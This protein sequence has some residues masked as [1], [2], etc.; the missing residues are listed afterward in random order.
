MANRRVPDTNTPVSRYR[1]KKIGD[2]GNANAYNLDYVNSST[3]LDWKIFLTAIMAVAGVAGLVLGI[4]AVGQNIALE[5]SLVTMQAVIGN[6]TVPDKINATEICADDIIVKQ[7]SNFEGEDLVLSISEG[8]QFIRPPQPA[9]QR[10]LDSGISG[11]T[12]G[13]GSPY[14]I[15]W[16]SSLI[17]DTTCFNGATAI[18]VPEDGRYLFGGFIVF[19]GLDVSITGLVTRIMAGSTEV[20]GTETSDPSSL[21]ST[22]T[23][24]RLSMACLGELSSSADL[25]VE[26]I[27]LPDAGAPH[28]IGISAESTF[29]LQR[30]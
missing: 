4:I 29:F 28:D 21:A 18:S 14:T 12:S 17:N 25:T 11:E 23:T 30:V 8:D 1:L 10:G 19:E 15:A 13:P 20:C 9:C 7:I 27:A 3:L 24:S 5:T 26:V 22:L 16:S 6:L 2:N